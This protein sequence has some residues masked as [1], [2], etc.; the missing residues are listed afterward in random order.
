MEVIDSAVSNL[1]DQIDDDTLK[2][3]LRAGAGSYFLKSSM[4]LSIGWRIRNEFRFPG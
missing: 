1:Q 3:M 2:K 4:T